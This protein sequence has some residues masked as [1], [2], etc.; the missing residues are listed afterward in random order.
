MRG[1]LFTAVLALTSGCLTVSVQPDPGGLARFA[2]PP[3]PRACNVSVTPLVLGH[4]KGPKCA[5]D[6]P[7]SCLASS[8]IVYVAYWVRLARASFLV[9]APFSRD[10]KAGLHR[11][12]WPE[13]AVLGFEQDASLQSALAQV[14]TPPLDF[15]LLT[16]AHWDHVD[17]LRELPGARVVMGPGEEAFVQA[18]PKDKPALVQPSAMQAVH[19]TSFAWDGP[20]YE[21]FP[22]SH[23]LLGD[24]CVVLVPLPGHTPGSVGV[25]VQGVRGRRLMFVGDSVWS[26]DALARPSHKL[27]PLS[28]LTDF[29]RAALSPTLWRLH[30]LMQHDPS[31]LVVPAHDGRALADVRA[32]GGT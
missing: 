15:V 23:D 30:H 20:A 25:F 19:L 32:L 27:K 13:R 10:A 24:G 14:G 21:N 29:D 4:A 9:D 5:A 31:L 18:Y 3:P 11:L 1:S 7:A 16:H 12:P 6:G 28:N 22:V 26:R 2:F 17:G 8:D